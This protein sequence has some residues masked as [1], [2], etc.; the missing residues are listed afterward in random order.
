MHLKIGLP[1]WID[2]NEKKIVVETELENDGGLFIFKVE[3]TECINTDPPNF[4]LEH[5]YW[6]LLNVLLL[7]NVALGM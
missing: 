1:D 4:S 2:K 5:T 7:V 6:F 3:K